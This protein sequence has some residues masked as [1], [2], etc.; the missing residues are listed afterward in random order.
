MNLCTTEWVRLSPLDESGE[1]GME[2]IEQNPINHHNSKQL[3]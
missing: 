1:E 2:T 3:I